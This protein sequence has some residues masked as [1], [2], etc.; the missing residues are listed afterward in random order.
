M[1]TPE[2]TRRTAGRYPF[3]IKEFRIDQLVIIIDRSNFAVAIAIDV[4]NFDVRQN[5]NLDFMVEYM[6]KNLR[7]DA[8]HI[9]VTGPFIYGHG[10]RVGHKGTHF[11]FGIARQYAELEAPIPA[12]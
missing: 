11:I 1:A 6:F 2:V 8:L 4:G 3:T 12:I 9:L 10:N 7:T 5:I